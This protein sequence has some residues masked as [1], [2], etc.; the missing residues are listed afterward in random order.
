MDRERERETHTHTRCHEEHL[1]AMRGD[2]LPSVSRQC[3]W[4]HQKL[5]I[6]E[7]EKFQEPKPRKVS[8]TSAH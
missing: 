2:M 1:R 3:P 4:A 6:D 7:V 8:W 5:R